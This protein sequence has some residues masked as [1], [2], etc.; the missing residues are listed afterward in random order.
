MKVISPN[1]VSAEIINLHS[2]A[3]SWAHQV[4]VKYLLELQ[5]T[6][7]ARSKKDLRKED[8][9]KILKAMEERDLFIKKNEGRDGFQGFDNIPSN[10]HIHERTHKSI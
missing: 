8:F 3:L 10:I 1:N 5:T 2:Q 9:E 4:R 7:T 6:E